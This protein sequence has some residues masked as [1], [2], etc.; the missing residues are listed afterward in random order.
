MVD[1]GPAG[2]ATISR[3]NHKTNGLPEGGAEVLRDAAGQRRR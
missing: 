2:K 3:R 1:G